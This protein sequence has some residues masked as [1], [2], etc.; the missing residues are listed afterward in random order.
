MSSDKI[1]VDTTSYT[2]RQELITW[3]DQSKLRAANVLVVGAGALGNEIVKN[4][5]LVG[6]GNITIVDMD[7]IELSNLSRC[8]FFRESDDGSYKA[9]VLAREAERLNPFTKTR[10][11]TTP[12]QDLGDAYLQQF[13]LI[14][15][16]LDNR[17]ARVWLGG[18]ARRAGKVWI[19][20][21]I[22]GLMGKVQTFTPDG[23]CYACT[24]SEK[25]WELLAH[26][27]ACKLLGTDEIL[28]GHTPTNATTSSI[29]AGIQTQ[30][31]IKYLAEVD[32]SMH[33]L[34]NKVWRMIGEQMAT[35]SSIIE[36]DEY[37]PFHFDPIETT[38]QT[39]LPSTL[40]ELWS[41]LSLDDDTEISFYD[42]FLFIHGCSACGTA[43]TFGYKDLLKKQGVCHNCGA[44]RVVDLQ[45]RIS[46]SNEITTLPIEPEFWPQHSFA[47][48]RK[49]DGQERIEIKR[50]A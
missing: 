11:F 9:E 45:S 24:M 18:A 20:A 46:K 19:D 41:S 48:I 10:F 14:I 2:A 37:C 23:P 16:G 35:F 32:S 36:I 5:A 31:A 39:Q 26:R 43:P 44:E 15:A 30:E 29:I 7:T 49:S 1:V 3:W 42:D 21:A 33:A 34:E 40:V 47:Q 8:I 27:K 28:A 6:V 13:N 50:G 38:Q 25:D 22:E 4:L 12:V 17:E